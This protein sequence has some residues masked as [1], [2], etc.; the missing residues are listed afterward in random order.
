M[1]ATGPVSIDAQEFGFARLQILG[2]R[3]ARTCNLWGSK[4]LAIR[5]CAGFGATEGLRATRKRFMGVRV[6][7]SGLRATRSGLRATRERFAGLRVARSGLRGATRRRFG[8]A[9][10]CEY[11]GVACE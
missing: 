3:G 10:A 6:A 1:S 5:P 2:F 7:R 11:L 8:P 4:V 9:R